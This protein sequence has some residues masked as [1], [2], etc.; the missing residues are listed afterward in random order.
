MM[1][2]TDTRFWYL[3]R[4]RT[5]GLVSY[6]VSASSL[7]KAMESFGILWK[8]YQWVQLKYIDIASIFVNTKPANANWQ[9]LAI[10]D[11]LMKVRNESLVL[12]I[13]D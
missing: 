11:I 5:S 13:A 1:I 12:R 3:G 10:G 7:Q 4:D 2:T 6:L 9:D 8:N